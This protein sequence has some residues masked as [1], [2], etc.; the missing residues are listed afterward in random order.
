M[1]LRGEKG[2]SGYFRSA[3]QPRSG[4]K[5]L[6]GDSEPGFAGPPAAKEPRVE[7][8]L[9]VGVGAEGRNL[10]EGKDWTT[11]GSHPELRRCG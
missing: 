10:A 9:P 6:W 7:G 5:A 2:A 3:Q 11:G 4:G 8:K 1:S